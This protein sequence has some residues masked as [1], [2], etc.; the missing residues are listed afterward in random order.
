ML[1]KIKYFEEDKY[2]I[3]QYIVKWDDIDDAIERF[4]KYV[5]KEYDDYDCSYNISKLRWWDII[6]IE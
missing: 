5:E 3:K 1:F 6:E 2:V 4:D